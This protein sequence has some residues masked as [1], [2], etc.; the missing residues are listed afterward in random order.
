M[1]MMT[2]MPLL[3]LLLFIFSVEELLDRLIKMFM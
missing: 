2:L 3:P 1:A